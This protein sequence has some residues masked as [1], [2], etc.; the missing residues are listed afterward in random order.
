VTVKPK[1]AKFPFQKEFTPI[2]ANSIFIRRGSNTMP[3]EGEI[4]KLP[5]GN[6]N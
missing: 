6:R 2:P 4:E 1:K 5:D 3:V